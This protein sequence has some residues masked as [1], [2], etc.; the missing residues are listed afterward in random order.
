MSNAEGIWN[1]ESP[2]QAALSISSFRLCHSFDI[3][4]SEF[5]IP[6]PTATTDTNPPRVLLLMG[7]SGCGKTTV[8]EALAAQLGCR[9]VDADD[10]HPP[11]NKAKMS[12]KVPLSDEDRWPW[13]RRV[14][15]EMDAIPP[16]QQCV[17]GCSAL[18]RAYRR[19]LMDGAEGVRLIYLR[20][21]FEL[22]AARL[23]A[24]QGH[25]MP[26]DLLRSQFAALE[27]PG[28]DEG[29]SVDIAPD[30]AALVAQCLAAAR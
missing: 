26:P 11:E 6:M 19:L 13:L 21:T 22:I 25:F 28:P 1:Q 24:R 3:R 18:K 14:R 17:V 29:V 5:V 4:H 27:E 2:A 12:A 8:G 16:G 10:L 30:T 15:A 20:G 7:V 23:A 9:F